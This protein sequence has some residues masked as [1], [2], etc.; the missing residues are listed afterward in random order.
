MPT[1]FVTGGTGFVG[2]NLVRELT[3]RGW[4]VTACHRAGSNL[5]LLQRWGPRLVRADV[6]EPEALLAAMPE[7]PDAVFHLAASVNFWR[8]RNDEQTRVN[9]EGTRHV[10]E[11]ALQRRARR[12]IHMS[13]LAAWAPAD[14]DCIDETTPS[15]AE[16]HAVNYFRTK[17]L[18]EREVQNGIERGLDA[19]FINPGNI[20]G[21]LDANIWGRAFRMVQ[22][23][24]LPLVPPGAAPFCHVREVVRAVVTAV[25]QGRSG[26]RY[27]LGGTQASYRELFGLVCDLLGRRCPPVAP[28][29]LLSSLAVA[30]D[31][32]SRITRELPDLTPDMAV[33]LGV[34]F[35]ARSAKAERELG[36]QPVAFRSM[37]QDTFEWL[38]AEQLI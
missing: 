31:A 9:V 27:I 8:P 33:V 13:S 3:A 20:L 4:E 6:V 5:A 1:A 37:V 7:R 2:L 23:G 21:P 29:W 10:V 11:A 38:R 28:R 12:F 18:A 14:G 36:F 35:E 25:D 30:S 17:W 24:R 26:E 16:G 22:R 32:V 19:C 15:K 34:S